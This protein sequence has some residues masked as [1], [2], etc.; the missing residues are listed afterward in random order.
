MSDAA[1]SIDGLSKA[2]GALKAVD[3]VSFS[4]SRGSIHALLGEN[5][6]GKSTLVKMLYGALQPDAGSIEVGGKPTAIP[7]PNHARALGIGMV[8]QHFSLFESMTVAENIALAL[9]H[10]PTPDTV[11]REL[12]DF[13]G[14]YG[15]AVDADAT[16][17]DLDVGVRQRVEILRV[18]L[19]N[20]SLVIL[21]E[22]TSVLTPQEAE[23]L[24]TVLRQLASEGKSVLYISHKLEEVRALCDAATV[25]RRGKVVFRTD[26]KTET[27]ASLA[28]AMV[29]ADVAEVVRTEK[30]AAQSS[31]IVLELNEV[32]H[33]PKSLFGMPLSKV[34]CTIH[35]GQIFGIAGVAGNGQKE[36]FSILS[37]EAPVPLDAIRLLGKPVGTS[38]IT[39]RREM[40]AAFVPEERGGHAAVPAM[41]LSENAL[42]TRRQ[43]DDHTV[44]AAGVIRFD[45][46]SRLSK[47][48]RKTFDVRSADGDPNAS[49][50]SGGNLQK[51]VVGRELSRA[52]KLLVVNQPTWGVDASAA[53]SIR[54]GLL[55][56]AQSGSAVIVISQD[57]DELLQISDMI[58]V[59]SHGHLSAP[60][61]RAQVT[62]EKLGLLMGGGNVGDAAEASDE[63]QA[64]AA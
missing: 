27:A 62:L 18:L 40:G 10:R 48:I 49:T 54:H 11:K 16:V 60:I 52:P 13:I 25:M 23:Q 33:D 61:P 53:S 63:R 50:L 31:G 24:F 2:F 26:P 34:S 8:F 51:F 46:V 57:L 38:S 20:P 58:S 5:G 19:Q 4:I 39:K 21:D 64:D 28:R 44:G 17:G 3:D 14:R 1:L 36:L 22:P 47:A 45:A 55:E 56:L 12:G 7:S 29:G 41:S 43:D 42:L 6:A 15:L 35:E 59:L 9:D 32:D 37:G 30:P